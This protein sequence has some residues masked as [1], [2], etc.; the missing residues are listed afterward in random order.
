MGMV[1]TAEKVFPSGAWRISGMVNGY[2]VS[3]VYYGFTKSAAI[4]E[5]RAEFQ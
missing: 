1:L 2:R 3:R 5:F 4:A